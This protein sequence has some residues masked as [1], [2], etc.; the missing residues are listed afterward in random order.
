MF[1]TPNIFTKFSEIISYV[2]NK[3][4]IL[5][6]K[7]FHQESFEVQMQVKYLEESFWVKKAFFLAQ[8]HST[9]I[10]EI[11][12]ENYQEII[13]ADACYS[14][15]KHISLNVIVADCVPILLY[16][17]EKQ[18]IWAMHAGWKG[19]AWNIL[20]K[21]LETLKKKYGS[22]MKDLI[23]FIWPSICAKCYEVGQEVAQNFQNTLLQKWEKFFLDLKKENL[24]Q[25]LHCGVPRENIELSE[26]CTFELSEK[27]FSYR[28]EKSWERFICGIGIK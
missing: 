1:Q 14:K 15:M 27:Y 16:D 8:C 12:H 21:T 9:D 23:V 2:G 4:H 28:R 10:I 3:E 11:T 13:F 22:E 7:Q 18:I 24:I 20:G 6:S 25:A 17:R 19:S 5:R 26:E